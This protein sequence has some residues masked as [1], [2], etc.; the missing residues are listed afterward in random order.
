M[1]TGLFLLLLLLGLPF[2]WLMRDGMGPGA[3]ES[4]GMAAV[5]KCLK[6]FY[7]GP[8]LGLLALAVIGG[9]IMSYSPRDSE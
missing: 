1:L 9:W 8:A 2:A 4:S 6:T 5:V 3:V 7:I